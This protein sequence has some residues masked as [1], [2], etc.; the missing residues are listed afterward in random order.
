MS[1]INLTKGQR[2]SLTKE[3][4]SALDKVCVGSNWGAIQKKGW[5]GGT[6]TK[7]VDLDASIAVFDKDGNKLDLIY[8]GNKS[9][10]GIRHSG[11]DTVGDTD[12]DDGLDNEVI[13]VELSKVHPQ[14]TYLALVLNSFNRVDFKDIPFASARIYSGTAS[15]VD[16]VH[17]KMDIANDPK[18]AGSLCMI[19]GGF[20]KKNGE[21]K[22]RAIGEP[23]SDRTLDALVETVR[24]QYVN[25]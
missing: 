12:G 6:T 22:F 15:R 18:F 11:D 20:Y 17:A 9:A 25:R 7:S 3:N 4:G 21:W 8:F 23:T 13:T 14:A 2:I 19:M 1:V 5:L 24:T 16:E 10:P